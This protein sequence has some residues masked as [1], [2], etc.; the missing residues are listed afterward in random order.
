MTQP[1]VRESRASEWEKGPGFKAELVP[2]SL[3]SGEQW[4]HTSPA[5]ARRTANCVSAFQPYERKYIILNM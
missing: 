5:A 1:P 2:S 3:R 4:V